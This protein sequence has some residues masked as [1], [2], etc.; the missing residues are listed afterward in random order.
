MR[1]DISAVSRDIYLNSLETLRRLDKHDHVT[2]FYGTYDT[3]SGPCTVI[4][5]AQF[6]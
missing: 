1:P 4:E 5:F 3:P 6:G 2:T